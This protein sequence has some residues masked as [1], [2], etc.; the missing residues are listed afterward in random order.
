L[1]THYALVSRLRRYGSLPH[2][3]LYNF[4]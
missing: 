1:I 2:H 3:Y 4:L